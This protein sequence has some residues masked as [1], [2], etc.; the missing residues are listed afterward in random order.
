[1]KKLTWEMKLG[2]GLLILSGLIYLTKFVIL[3][4][5]LNTYL[6]VFNSLG[7]LPI[8][9]LLVTLIINQLLSMRAK[10][11]RLEKLNMVIGTFYS[12][13]GTSLLTTFSRHDPTISTLSDRLVVRETWTDPEFS[14]MLDV[15]KGH[16]YTIDITQVD[17]PRCGHF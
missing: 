5:P 13:V 16:S 12:E 9:V 2:I 14:R 3:G 11:E 6:Y 8:N 7:F 17:L 10:R 1:M 4:D 15:L